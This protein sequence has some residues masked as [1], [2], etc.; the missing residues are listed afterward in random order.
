MPR[1][2]VIEAAG[3]CRAADTSVYGMFLKGQT[4]KTVQ[5]ENSAMCV[6]RCEEEVRCQSYNF[7]IGQNICELND[8]TKEARPEDFMLDDQLLFMRRTFSRGSKLPKG[9]LC[10]HGVSML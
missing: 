7:V 8:K 1:I 2:G 9:V 5:A 4:F 3:Q 6:M 10:V